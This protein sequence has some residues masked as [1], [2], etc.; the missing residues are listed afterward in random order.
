MNFKILQPKLIGNSV[1]TI[2][3]I[4]NRLTFIFIINRKLFFFIYL[5]NIEKKIY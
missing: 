5:L 4:I 2:I 3:I 1:N